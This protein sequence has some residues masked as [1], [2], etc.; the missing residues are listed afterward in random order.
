VLSL[1]ATG[2]AALAAPPGAPATESR[3]SPF[4]S[5]SP[6]A[7]E[8]IP[9]SPPAP[10][11]SETEGATPVRTPPALPGDYQ[12]ALLNPKDT[13]RAYLLDTCQY[14][15]DK[16][17]PANASPGTVVMTVMFHSVTQDE[18]TRDN[19]I[20]FDQFDELMQG[21]KA[22]GFE[23]INATQLADFLE[24]NA[25]IPP[26]SVLLLAD[27]RHYAWYFNSLFLPYYK[28]YG[29]PV[30][31]AWIS[32][33]DA[34]AGLWQENVDLEQEGWVDHQA[35]GVVHNI[36]A[37]PGSTDEYLLGELQGSVDA[38]QEHFG[39]RPIAYIWPGGGF[40]PRS[41]E[42]ARESGY[43]LGFTVNPRGPVMFN[44]VP[45][46][47]AED[48]MRPSYIPE[49]PAADPLLTLPRYW[50]TDALVH[51]GAVSQI[52]DEAAAY[53]AQNKAAELEY[54]DIICAET[55]GPLSTE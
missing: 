5:G 1:I 11:L 49:G 17:D 2:C 50:D 54:Y 20:S 53:A 29:W 12:T 31:N 42:L 14:L 28:K 15:H 26:R 8:T 36:P 33:T 35:H 27:D 10:P 52:G 23:A 16:W 24:H 9:P 13:P 19:Q 7:S 44:W 51:L 46:A 40:T 43:R 30:V 34:P 41:V 6:P 39:K 21:L 55:H 4:I 45:Q 18:V 48:D 38:F 47:D 3:L 32:A 37:G 25:R 22:N